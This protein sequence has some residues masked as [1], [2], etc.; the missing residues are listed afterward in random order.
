MATE[1]QLGT[2]NE[3]QDATGSTPLAGSSTPLAQSS[4]PAPMAGSAPQST[5]SG[6]PNIKQYLNAN[7]GAG[8]KLSQGIQQR[9]GVDQQAY[10]KNVDDT[11]NT[12]GSTA[13]D[14]QKKTGEEGQKTIQTA[15]KDPSALLAEQNKTQLDE[16]NKLKTGGYGQDIGNLQNQT[17]QQ[18]FGLQNQLG[19][20]QSQANLANTE[21]GRFQLLQQ[22]FGTPTY[23]KGQ[24]RLDQM[25]LQAQ[26]GSTQDLQKGLQSGYQSAN[27]AYQGLDAN[28][29]SRL[30]A[31]NSLVGERQNQ[32]T[33]LLNNGA[34]AAGLDANIGDRGLNDINTSV[35]A[36]MEKAKTLAANGYPG[37]VDRLKKNQLTNADMRMLGL[38]TDFFKST[39]N[40]HIPTTGS[41]LYNVDLSKYLAD[42]SQ[43]TNAT[44]AQVANPEEFAR[45]R[46]LQQL[47]GDNS[48]DIFG[49][50]TEAGGYHPYAYNKDELAKAL[51][52]A[53]GSYSGDI[54]KFSAGGD[55]AERFRRRFGA[56][57]KSGPQ[58]GMLPSANT[59]EDFNA[60]KDAFNSQYNPASAQYQNWLNNTSAG[61]D[62]AA[63]MR[64]INSN[65]AA[66]NNLQG[67]RNLNVVGEGEDFDLPDYW[68]TK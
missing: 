24:Q 53:S 20:L 18:K 33:G 67:S 52:S 27:Q 54:N 58:A 5:P 22:S 50:A 32:W 23:S 49:G 28:T 38:D 59:F 2:D 65:N 64:E 35:Q 40:T 46:A 66:V 17:Q 68:K 4:G 42:G 16:F 56:G 63:I 47:S 3:E 13:D 36:N 41:S 14:L 25:F 39:N 26:P 15:F 6:R 34:D 19:N 1:K 8:D 9:Y 61:Y 44:A 7:Q 45:Y 12:F 48:G 29:T 30:G 31:L 43:A 11:K 10:Q 21:G 60:A 37:M 55:L 62:D 51:Q 57:V